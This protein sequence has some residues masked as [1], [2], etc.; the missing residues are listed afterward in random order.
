MLLKVG[1]I[2]TLAASLCGCSLNM[3]CENEV[4][5]RTPSP[6]GRTEAVLFNRSCGATT[7]YARHITII[8]KASEPHGAGDIFIADG[9]PAVTVRWAGDRELVVRYAPDAHVLKKEPA[10]S[11]V[12]IRY[13]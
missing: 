10:Y 11:A 13:E 12:A 7:G 4:L 6:N 3:P 2:I 9:E 8:P 5:S 1:T